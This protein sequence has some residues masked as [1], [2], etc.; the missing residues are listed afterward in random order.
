MLK[1]IQDMLLNSDP[2]DHSRYQLFG[3]DDNNGITLSFAIK[4]NPANFAQA[5]IIRE[6]NLKDLPKADSLF[7]KLKKS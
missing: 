1:L 4:P 2:E 7:R 6:F 5:F 3:N